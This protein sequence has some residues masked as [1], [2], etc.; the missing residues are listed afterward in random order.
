TYEFKP[1]RKCAFS[2][3]VENTSLSLAELTASRSNRSSRARPQ[4]RYEVATQPAPSRL[5]HLCRINVPSCSRPFKIKP[6]AALKR[7]RSG[8]PLRATA[9]R[10]SG[11]GEGIAPLGPNLENEGSDR[12]GASRVVEQVD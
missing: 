1:G 11:R 10:S 3:H 5:S 12:I 7:G 2:E 6:S 4:T 9:L 8:P